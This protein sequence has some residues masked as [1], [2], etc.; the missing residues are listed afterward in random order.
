MH[1]VGQVDI[2]TLP[3]QVRVHT[4]RPGKD[5]GMAMSLSLFHLKGSLTLIAAFE[6][7][8]TTVQRLQPSGTWAMTYRAKAHSQPVLSLDVHPDLDYFFTSSADAIIARHPV[9]T[10]RQELTPDFDPR[11]RIIEEVEAD[12]ESGTPPAGSSLLSAQLKGEQSSRGHAPKASLKEW[13]Y[14]L[15]RVD[16]KHAGQQGLRIRSDGRIFA[17]AGWDSKVRVYSCKTMKELAVLQW[18][19]VGCY[20][21][22]FAG[23][24]EATPG[25][26]GSAPSAESTAGDSG[27][28]MARGATSVK[29]RRLHRARTAH[30]IAAGAKDGKVSMWD[31]Y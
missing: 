31:I 19:K 4:V 13:E 5:T 22:A 17:T 2:Y 23:V 12:E 29:S 11:N 3:S 21:V 10:A 1:P 15:D 20:A 26:A 24:S 18:H 14:P 27:P 30:W 16:T 8:Y 9:P 7:G 28:L 6:N 25:S